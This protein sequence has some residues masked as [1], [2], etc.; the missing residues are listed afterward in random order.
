MI[1]WV[2]IVLILLNGKGGG[3][4]IFNRGQLVV[5]LFL[6]LGRRGDKRPFGFLSIITVYIGSS[7][8]KK[9]KEN[10]K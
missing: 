9:E 6:L 4:R 7:P 8:R 2:N 5:Y 3:G 10:E 1:N